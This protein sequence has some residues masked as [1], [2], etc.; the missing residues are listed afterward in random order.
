MRLKLFQ[1]N[2]IYVLLFRIAEI[3]RLDHLVKLRWL[4]TEDNPVDPINPPNPVDLQRLK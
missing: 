2:W 3:P 1:F 4:F